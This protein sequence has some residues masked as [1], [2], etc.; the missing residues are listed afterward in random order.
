MSKPSDF[1]PDLERRLPVLLR[2]AW[3]PLNQAFRR[4]IAHLD[5]TPDQFTALRWLGESEQLLT[6]RELT[7]RMA[8]DPNTIASLLRRM[9]EAGLI[10]RSPDPA[11]RRANHIK[12]TRRGRAAFDKA[13][14]VAIELQERVLASIPSAQRDAFLRNL[15]R[16][17]NA[18]RDA[19]DEPTP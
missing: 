11:D 13:R 7:E 15:C 16:V 17:A 18:A 14:K 8:S 12:P 5:L 6:Q 4:R 10:A 2:G 19:A 1:Q 9:E 3:F